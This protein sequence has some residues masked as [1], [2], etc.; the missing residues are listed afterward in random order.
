[1]EQN[2]NWGRVTIPTDVDVIPETLEIMK[3]LNEVMPKGVKIL[4]AIEPEDSYPNVG[5]VIALA[6]YSF[7]TKDGKD[8]S[9]TLTKILSQEE[10]TIE[11]KT[12]FIK[13]LF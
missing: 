2:R 7:S 10:I 1:M 13:I 3:R 8:Y 5:S 11:K 9:A 6:E 12:K 4:N